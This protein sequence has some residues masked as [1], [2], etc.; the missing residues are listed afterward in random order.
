MATKNVENEELKGVSD[1]EITSKLDLTINKDDLMDI[2]I[3]RELTRLEK[4][5]EA[6]KAPLVPVKEKW[7]KFKA[8]A[9]EERRKRL[10]KLLPKEVNVNEEPTLVYYQDHKSTPLTFRFA[11]AGFEVSIQNVNT[12]LKKT[13]DFKKSKEEHEELSSKINSEVNILNEEKNMIEKAPK[14]VK[15]KM[16]TSFLGKGKDGKAILELLNKNGG[17]KMLG[18]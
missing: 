11:S 9:E 15:A 8:K 1:L 17:P 14:R 16:L 12:E 4:A 5:I 6:V 7:L 10:L 2:L 3:D 13:E 18:N